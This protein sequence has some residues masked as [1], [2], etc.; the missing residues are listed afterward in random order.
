MQLDTFLEVSNI[1]Q[2]VQTHETVPVPLSDYV[3]LDDVGRFVPSLSPLWNPFFTEYVETPKTRT[4]CKHLTIGATTLC[5]RDKCVAVWWRQMLKTAGT[6]KM[7]LGQGKTSIY[8]TSSRNHVK[9][10]IVGFIVSLWVCI[11]ELNQKLVFE[12]ASRN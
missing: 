10:P 12:C 3:G 11:K 6:W 5:H 9:P 8:I 2:N 4:L 1:I 7:V